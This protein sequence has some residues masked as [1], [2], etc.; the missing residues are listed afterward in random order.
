M[1]GIEK[2]G[3]IVLFLKIGGDFIRGRIRHTFEI[4]FSYRNISCGFGTGRTN[5][6]LRVEHI[7]HYMKTSTKVIFMCILLT[8]A[9]MKPHCHAKWIPGKCCKQL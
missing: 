4:W 9:K 3:G 1:T 6:K 5:F 7:K 8:R 2:R